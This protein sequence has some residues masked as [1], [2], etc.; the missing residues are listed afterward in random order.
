MRAIL[1]GIATV[2]ILGSAAVSANACGEPALSLE[3]GGRR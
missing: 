3:V 2:T 1:I